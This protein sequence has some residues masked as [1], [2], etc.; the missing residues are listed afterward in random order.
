MITKKE[1][2]RIVTLAQRGKDYMEITE[3]ILTARVPKILMELNDEV[4]NY[5]EEL[6]EKV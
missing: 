3:A 1:K 2:E 4:T 5:L 6:E